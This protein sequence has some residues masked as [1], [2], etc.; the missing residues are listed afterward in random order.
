MQDAAYTEIVFFCMAVEILIFLKMRLGM[1]KLVYQRTVAYVLAV[2]SLSMGLDFLIRF[3]NGPNGLFGPMANSLLRS[4]YFAVTLFFVFSWFRYAGYVLKLP[5]WNDHKRLSLY[6]L[7]MM[8]AL[9][10]VVLSLWNGCVFYVDDFNIYHRNDLY[11]SIYLPVCMLYTV[12]GM[13]LALV[14]VVQKRNYAERPIYSS[15]ASFGAL[16][17]V[18]IP[19]H[20][21]FNGSLPIIP[22]GI[23]LSTI[24]SFLLAQA[25]LISVDPLTHLNNRNQLHQFLSSKMRKESGR[26]RLYLFVIDLDKFK[27]IND[28]YGHNEGDKALVLVADVLKPVCGPRGCFIARFG[29]DEFNLVAELDDDS[30]ANEICEAVQAE[31]KKRVE[32]FKFPLALSIGYADNVT[33]VETL[34]EFFARADKRLYEQKKLKAG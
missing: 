2:A 31:L 10:L 12:A 27:Q 7:P 21:H 16:S 9:L 22:A 14:K 1:Y 29:G 6:G 19:L 18:V 5:F 25:H 28:T 3:V 13:V 20:V 33:G 8:V 26:K 11:F 23:M 4:F 32:T 34:P 15:A 17:I 24:Y 30:A